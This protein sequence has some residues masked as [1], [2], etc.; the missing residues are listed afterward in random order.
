MRFELTPEQWQCPMQ[1]LT[2]ILQIRFSL[3]R[4]LSPVSR[5]LGPRLIKINTIQ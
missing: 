1:P 2:P 4:K 3:D 5:H